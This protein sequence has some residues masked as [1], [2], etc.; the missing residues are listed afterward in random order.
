MKLDGKV[1]LKI[2]TADVAEHKQRMQRFNPCSHD[3]PGPQSPGHSDALRNWH[4]DATLRQAA[5]FHLP[6]RRLRVLF[7]WLLCFLRFDSN[8]RTVASP[9]WS[10]ALGDMAEQ[11]AYTLSP[12]ELH[13]HG[14][15]NFES[16]TRTFGL[17][18]R[19]WQ[20]SP[21]NVRNCNHKRKLHGI[22]VGII[23]VKV[24][25]HP[26]HIAGT[27]LSG[28]SSAEASTKPFFIT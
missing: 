19:Y 21:I 11:L 8:E 12:V 26:H 20:A 4:C 16:S 2:L 24:K 28:L 23:L 25:H 18:S 22:A 17:I 1:A 5:T 9:D 7:A 15:T 27:L 14:R 13:C 10:I 3:R 6:C